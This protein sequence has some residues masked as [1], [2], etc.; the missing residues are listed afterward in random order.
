MVERRIPRAVEHYVFI[1]L[2]GER[3]ANNFD[4]W[5]PAHKNDRDLELREFQHEGFYKKR[6]NA[7]RETTAAAE[8][9]AGIYFDCPCCGYGPHCHPEDRPFLDHYESEHA[10]NQLEAD[11]LGEEISIYERLIDPELMGEAYQLLEGRLTTEQ[12]WIHFIKSACSSRKDYAEYR[13]IAKN[14]EELISEFTVTARK[15]ASLLRDLQNSGIQLPPELLADCRSDNEIFIRGSS[16]EL[17]SLRIQRFVERSLPDRTQNMPD[18]VDLRKALSNVANISDN[19]KIEFASPEISTAISTRQNSKKSSYLRAFGVL[20][21]KAK[22]SMNPA[23][24]KAMAITA[25]VVLDDAELSTSEDHVRKALK[26][27][28]SAKRE[29]V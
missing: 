25:N 10:R 12:Q 21:T 5:S 4:D 26:R 1:M 8:Q 14:A 7:L 29:N 16:E 6:S 19:M 15:L 3:E 20:L 22:I 9:I 23:I 11:R 27:A 18:R 24:I 2:V 13:R 28:K 17:R